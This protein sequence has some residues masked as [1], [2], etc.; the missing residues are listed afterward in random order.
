MT[1]RV[2]KAPSTTRP[3]QTRRRRRLTR[4]AGAMRPTS[5]VPYQRDAAEVEPLSD[6]PKLTWVLLPDSTGRM[7]PQA[8]WS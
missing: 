4:V 5:F 3:S 7:R 6:Q 1:R 8:R 2:S